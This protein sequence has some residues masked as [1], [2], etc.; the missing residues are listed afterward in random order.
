[1]ETNTPVQH[2]ELEKM[3]PV[4]LNVEFL[5]MLDQIP[6]QESEEQVDR[7]LWFQ[8]LQTLLNHSLITQSF[9]SFI[10]EDLTEQV[11][12]RQRTNEP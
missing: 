2:T 1:M 5:E 8:N 3:S 6:T 12:S 4:E 7:S 10:I 11:E 9:K